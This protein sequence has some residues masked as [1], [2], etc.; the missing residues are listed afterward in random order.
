VHVPPL[1]HAVASTSASAP[2]PI[3]AIAPV[4]ENVTDP[5]GKLPDPETV[6]VYVID[7]GGSPYVY[8]PALAPIV[9]VG[10]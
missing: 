8:D 5:V 6:A 2:D 9:T 7:D 4:P 10:V 3:I 1:E